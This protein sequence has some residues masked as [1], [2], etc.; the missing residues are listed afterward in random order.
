ML[1]LLE[2]LSGF[3][4]KS[5]DS[6]EV[7]DKVECPDQQ[8]ETYRP[9]HTLSQEVE[10]NNQ[11]LVAHEFRKRRSQLLHFILSTLIIYYR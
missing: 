2:V 6:I 4:V 1:A 7:V 11:I 8:A 9:D 5:R 3:S 10:H